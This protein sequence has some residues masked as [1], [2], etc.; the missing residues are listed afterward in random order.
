MARTGAVAR[1]GGEVREE[2]RG[3]TSGAFDV[4]RVE[5]TRTGDRVACL[6]GGSRM[7]MAVV[8]DVAL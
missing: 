2:P 8:E 4:R 6:D 3:T 1:T 7:W 5:V